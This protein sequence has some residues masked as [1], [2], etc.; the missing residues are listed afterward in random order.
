MR[1]AEKKG[2]DGMNGREMVVKFV[3]LVGCLVLLFTL[4]AKYEL[5]VLHI[6]EVSL[7]A[8]VED[9]NALACSLNWQGKK[10]EEVRRREVL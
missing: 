6:G 7:G 5:V 1:R 8:V 10:E 3:C 4:A 2:K 9:I